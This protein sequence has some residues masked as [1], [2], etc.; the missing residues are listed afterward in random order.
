M[1]VRSMSLYGLV[2]AHRHGGKTDVATAE[3]IVQELCGGQQARRAPSLELR[4]LRASGHIRYVTHALGVRVVNAT[5]TPT[6]SVPQVRYA[7]SHKR[8]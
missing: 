6:A 7:T 8:H 4:A 2:G 3:L 1:G 5:H